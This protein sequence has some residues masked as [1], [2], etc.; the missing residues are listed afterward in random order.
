MNVTA[1]QVS[2]CVSTQLEAIGAAAVQGIHRMEIIVKVTLCSSNV[3]TVFSM[4][5]Q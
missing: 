5:Q 1:T 3:F 4:H 2:R